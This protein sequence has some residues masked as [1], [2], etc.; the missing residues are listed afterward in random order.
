MIDMMHRIENKKMISGLFSAKIQSIES[1]LKIFVFFVL[2][3]GYVL[4]FLCLLLAS[5]CAFCGYAFA[6]ACAVC[7]ISGQSR[8]I[9]SILSKNPSSLSLK[10]IQT[11]VLLP[12][13]E[14]LELHD[15]RCY[16]H[17]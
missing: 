8:Q 17:W 16:I 10:D 11:T 7:F 9:S 5:L 4:L 14:T 1:C 2:F 3:C 6:C 15:S 12:S 13:I